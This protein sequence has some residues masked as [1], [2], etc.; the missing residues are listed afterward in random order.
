M[1]TNTNA[2][3]FIMNFASKVPG[4]VRG[5]CIQG[6]CK[7]TIEFNKVVTD[8]EYSLHFVQVV[9]DQTMLV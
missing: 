3:F 4:E 9:P 5:V 1:G 7:D 2:T 6:F 8:F